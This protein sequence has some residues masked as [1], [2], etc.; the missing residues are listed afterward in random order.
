M[1]R[2]ER[3]AALPTVS[4]V[5]PTYREA[6]NV[7]VLVGRVREV[8]RAHRL[9]IEMLIVDD[10]SG[11]GIEDAVAAL[12]AEPWVTLVV[13]GGA[14]SLS[15]AALEGLRR[16]R[17]EVLM[18]MDAD[19]SHPPEAIPRLLDALA[20]PDVDFV[21]ASRYVAGGSTDEGWGL[22]RRVNGAVA[23]IL[24]RPL[25]GVRDPTSGFFA[26]RRETFLAGVDLD[27]IGFKIGLELVVKCGCKNLREVPIHFAR[28]LHGRSKLDLR[29]RVRY[30]RHLK[31]LIDY[32]H[33]GLSGLLGL[34]RVRD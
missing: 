13:R 27:P 8:A 23:R 3:P 33:G 4:L 25:V 1:P 9:D 30:L 17:H 24:A 7:P 22:G 31:R 10:E 28:R 16:A 6:E 19:L 34:R 14:R 21:F 20:R 15:H 5:V 11:D 18:V 32:R 29:E 26:L 2:D 12:G